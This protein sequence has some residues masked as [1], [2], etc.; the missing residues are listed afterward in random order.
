MKINF[1]YALSSKELEKFEENFIRAHK[2]L[3]EKFHN[4]EEVIFLDSCRI[5]IRADKNLYD[6]NVQDLPPRAKTETILES[7]NGGEEK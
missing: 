2:D 6:L 4:V 3:K 7:L 1:P 5:K